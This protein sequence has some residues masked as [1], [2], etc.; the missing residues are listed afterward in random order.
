L[1][2]PWPSNRTTASGESGA[3]E[4]HTGCLTTN[5]NDA[6][7][8]SQSANIV[9]LPGEEAQTVNA[10]SDDPSQVFFTVGTFT[11]YFDQ[12]GMPYTYVSG[13]NEIRTLVA[14]GLSTLD[15]SFGSDQIQVT[16]ETGYIQ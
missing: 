7:E 5:P 4:R 2:R 11:V 15:I 8:P 3:T 6:T 12:Y 16:A 9:Y 10:S 1:R 13:V 14:Q